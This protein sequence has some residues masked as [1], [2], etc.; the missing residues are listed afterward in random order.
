[1]HTNHRSGLTFNNVTFKIHQVG[2]IEC[3]TA[4][5]VSAA[6]GYADT[7]S[8]HRLYRRYADEFTGQMSGVVKMDTPGGSQEARVFSLRGA[9]LMGM[10]AKTEQAKQFRRWVLD[11][12]E[13]KERAPTIPADLY[14]QA[15]Q[16]ER[17]EAKSF[18]LA[19]TGS[20]LMLLRKSE[21]QE[22]Q[23]QVALMREAVQLRLQLGFE[24]ARIGGAA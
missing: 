14:A 15:L 20:R 10:L 4:E 5:Q 21:K 7:S 8:V 3:V 1:M 6:I 2:A 9:H 23:E 11:V 18:A 24:P 16:A 12:I 19:Q 22:L 13:S 17:D